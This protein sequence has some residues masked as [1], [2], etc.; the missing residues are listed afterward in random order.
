MLIGIIY[1]VVIVLANTIGAVSGMGGGVL[2]KPI[3]D[4]IGAHSVAT[5]SF[6]ATVAI[7]VMS[8]VSTWRQ[9]KKGSEINFHLAGYVAA[10]SIVGG[11]LGNLAFELLLALFA[12]ESSV[13][14]IQIALTLVTLIFALLYSC[15]DWKHYRLKEG[16]WYVIAGLVLGF[17][18]SL[19]GIGGG[20]INVSLLMLLF[21]MPIKQATLYSIT[22]IFFSQLA[23]LVT[24]AFA[25]GFGRFDLSMLFYVIPAA[26]LGGVLGSQLSNILSAK[27]VTLVFQSFLVV[28]LLI[29]LYNGWQI[30]VE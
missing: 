27:K 6:Y 10:G 11:I 13:K 26:I 28:V 22:T 16:K 8:F 24:I 1:F 14:L 7:F 29:N 30:V 12:E 19:L 25:T 17:L 21:S 23:K 3:L 2:I 4:L 20:P 5:I 9:V 15:F 18:A